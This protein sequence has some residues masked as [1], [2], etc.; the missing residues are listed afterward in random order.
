MKSARLSETGSIQ[1]SWWID[2]T[3]LFNK[4]PSKVV[5]LS[6]GHGHTKNND[7]LTKKREKIVLWKQMDLGRKSASITNAFQQAN[8]TFV[9]ISLKKKK[10]KQD[11]MLAYDW[12]EIE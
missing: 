10:K 4:A 7:L 8:G 12:L 6:S 9:G 3:S 11:P 1:I 5:I 2:S